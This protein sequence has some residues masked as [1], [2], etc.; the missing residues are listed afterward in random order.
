MW[1]FCIITFLGE[2]IVTNIY[3]NVLEEANS[4]SETSANLPSTIT[5]RVNTDRSKNLTTKVV[6]NV[7][8]GNKFFLPSDKA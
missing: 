7:S 4:F 5:F 2:R 1:T 6:C 8:H 3:I